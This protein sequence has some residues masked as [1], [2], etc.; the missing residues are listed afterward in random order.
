MDGAFFYLRI[1]GHGLDVNALDETLSA[2]PS[3]EQRT[4]IK[5]GEVLTTKFETFV[6][7]EDCWITEYNSSQDQSVDEA[8]LHFISAYL[9]KRDHLNALAHTNNVSFVCSL[10][11]ESEQYHLHFTPEVLTALGNLGIKFDF[12]FAFLT[13]YYRGNT[14]NTGG[15]PC[16]T[17]A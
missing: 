14:N 12:D 15:L 1:A 4:F 8:I 9:P 16:S 11:P 17:S 2:E 10:Y 5:E 3:T 7:K 6:H 13:V